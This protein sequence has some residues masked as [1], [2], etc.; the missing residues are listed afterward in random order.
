MSPSNG[1]NVLFAENRK[2][3]AHLEETF[4]GYAKKLTSKCKGR[5]INATDTKTT[6]R[7]TKGLRGKL[8]T[9]C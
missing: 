4:D 9:F 6:A 2:Q 1:G 5:Q 7:K 8:L 3:I